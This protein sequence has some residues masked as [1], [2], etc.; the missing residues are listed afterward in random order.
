MFELHPEQGLFH[1]RH[2]CTPWKVSSLEL[3]ASF[4]PRILVLSTEV[5]STGV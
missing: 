4:P 1:S 5:F 2:F 3:S